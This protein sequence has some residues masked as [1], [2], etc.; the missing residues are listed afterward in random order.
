[1]ADKLPDVLKAARIGSSLPS[2]RQ[3]VEQYLGV[4]LGHQKGRLRP[5]AWESYEQI[6]RLVPGIGKIVLA[7]LKPSQLDARFRRHQQDG[8]SA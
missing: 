3:T 5:R 4:W 7:R 2:E 8:A 6:V 1:V